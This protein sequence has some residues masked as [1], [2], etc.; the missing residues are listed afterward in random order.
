MAGVAG[1]MA[2]GA[3]S[4][5][6]LVHEAALRRGGYTLLGPLGEALLLDQ[7]A[8]EARRPD[9]EGSGPGAGPLAGMA[10][11]AGL[12]RSLQRFLGAASYG[13]LLPQ[14]LA[15]AAQR[16]GRDGGPGGAL[17]AAR[18]TELARLLRRYRS[19]LGSRFLDAGL[20]W[21]LGLQALA[22]SP[23]PELRAADVIEVHGLH[24]ALDAGGGG[25]G[26]E[27]DLGPTPH[28]LLA[29][30][31]A[32]ARTGKRVEVVLPDV[33]EPPELAL[34]VDAS[35]PDSPLAAALGPLLSGLHRHHTLDLNEAPAPLG[36][37]AD[38]ETPWGGFV[39][40]LFAGRS[41]PAGPP[42]PIAELPAGCV[43]LAP[44]P[45]P[46]AE[47]L[48]VAAAVR[49]LLDGGVPPGALAVVAQSPERR[50]RLVEAL[51]RYRVP[52]AA[53]PL[54]PTAAVLGRALPPPLTLLLSIYELLD[55]N[56]AGRGREGVPR[57]GLILL[58]SSSYLRFP[59]LER[60]WHLIRA[61]R[62]AGVRELHPAE[63][64]APAAPTLFDD[65]PVPG[66]E[67]GEPV[68]RTR[69]LQWFRQQ[70][71]ARRDGAGTL[72]AEQQAQLEHVD[73][74][75]RELYELPEDAP[76]S[77]H[78]AALRR[79]CERLGWFRRCLAPLRPPAPGS[80]DGEAGDRALPREGLELLTAE[81][82][83]R[84]RDAAAASALLR[85]LDELPLWARRL[86]LPAERGTITRPRF[87]GL[88]R[89][90][91]GRTYVPP[92]AGLG[93]ADEVT[94]LPSE[95]AVFVGELGC[96]P[97]RPRQH[98]F[99][100]GLLDGELPARPP[101]DVLLDDDDRRSL[102]RLLDATVWA[103]SQHD[104]VRAPLLLCE[105]LSH[106]RA[107]HLSWPV[108]DDEGRPLLR[109][110]WVEAVQ[111]AA[112]PGT[113]PLGEP[114][115]L[116]TP[117]LPW[118]DAARHP[119]ELWTRAALSRSLLAVDEA[120]LVGSGPGAWARRRSAPALLPVLAGRERAR[121]ASLRARLAIEQS[122]G[123]W[124]T[125]LAA[126]AEPTDEALEPLAGPFSGRLGAPQLVALLQPRLP[127]S[128]KH[129]LSASAL[130]DYAKC[131]FRFF[132]RRVLKA[133]PLQEGG[134]DLDPLA[135]GRLHHAVLERFFLERRK[136]ARLPLRGDDDDRAAF[137]Q[138]LDQEL[139]RF[140]Q[141]ERTGHPAL[142]AVRARRLR[143]DLWRLIEREA[144]EPIEEGLLP[145][146]FE[147]RFGPLEIAAVRGS[148]GEAEDG[149]ALHIEGII[150]RVDVG[151]GPG[152]VRA[153]VL[154]YKAGRLARYEELLGPTKLLQTSFQL[155][156]Y[157]A[158][159]TVDPTLRARAEEAGVAAAPVRVGARYYSLRQGR[160]TRPMADAPELISLDPAVRRQAPEH[161]VAEVAYRLWRR[162][163]A[164]DF[165]VAPRTCEGCGL[166]AV[167]RI[168]RAAPPPEA[169]A[170]TPSERTPSSG[171]LVPSAA[172]PTREWPEAVERGG[173]AP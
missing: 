162:L 14:T 124:F 64:A 29:A 136:S 121:A 42:P 63:R 78:A 12:R 165:R 106:S 160:V 19:L 79:L 91:L 3:R 82:A 133:T 18:V 70:A 96:L 15:R 85:V 137:S 31:A 142:F 45:S 127:G 37:Y 76:L 81:L 28:A 156:L 145:A 46:R 24:R 86:G 129:A 8:E 25:A 149:M 65:S 62:A 169:E 100:C 113:E 21:Q 95:S 60:P 74:A 71:S 172:T 27:G 120:P 90:A 35:E 143:E 48:H 104:A 43:T 10:G 2:G 9:G 23:P 39:L 99:L 75:V 135:S 102:A 97:V 123:R 163:R 68:W 126:V 77:R 164:G 167:C 138:A 119:A 114:P 22:E 128:P 47:A 30:V 105:A 53:R 49:E 150:D 108:A 109:S 59:G 51:G 83:A 157:A 16:L 166:E 111:R 154:D 158:A 7:L 61:L 115:R 103:G 159:L 6:E 134:E 88:L 101:E 87:A 58:L 152:G 110:S 44:L 116:R 1:E 173:G 170:A 50:A 13:A 147:H 122:R 98:L 54:L 38:P 94:G 118:P 20:A 171:P 80:L 112:R 17:R 4:L 92:G 36:P 11:T 125:A 146:L 132:V 161:N 41:R 168:S 130:E 89:A 151:V 66:G 153:L 56:L 34:S 107:A 148:P 141:Q 67:P 155:P 139:G 32:L 5:P 131:P 140:A 40:R 33:G 144:R 73:A 72:S 117:L 84:A 55:G 52:V 69:L 26:G 93:M 57:E